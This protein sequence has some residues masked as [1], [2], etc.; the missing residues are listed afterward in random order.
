MSD[1]V[2]AT[3]AELAMRDALKSGDQDRYF[4]VLAH[5]ELLLPVPAE[6]S[7]RSQTGWGT[8]AS[9]GRTHVLAFTSP[10]A[11]RA[12]LAEHAG[13]Y[14]SMTF[15][16]L[17]ANWPDQAWWL[18]VDPG[19]AIEG[20]LPAWYI[21][22]LATKHIE[23]T[24]KAAERSADTRLLGRTL[25]A[26]A[27]IE[28]ARRLAARPPGADSPQSGQRE[29]PGE[30]R[31]VPGE[32]RGDRTLGSPPEKP[33]GQQPQ[34]EVLDSPQGLPH[35]PRSSSAPHRESNPLPIAL[36][37]L[38]E[39]PPTGR[40][41]GFGGSLPERQQ[42][43]WGLGATPPRPNRDQPQ[44][45]PQPSPLAP[46]S[47]RGQPTPSHH[48]G[49]DRRVPDDRRLPP[50]PLPTRA[51]DGGARQPGDAT[52]QHPSE[53]L[54]TRGTPR[55]GIDTGQWPVVIEGAMLESSTQP[56]RA[57]MAEAPVVPSPPS[58]VRRPMPAPTAVKA[59]EPNA[60][61]ASSG[62]DGFTPVNAV[63]ENLLEAAKQRRTDR[64]LS[65]LLLAKVLVPG[66][67]DNDVPDP[68]RWPVEEIA[69]APH[70]VAYTSLE[71]LSG[72]LGTDASGGWARFT[73]L[74]SMW[75][76]D[77]LSFAVNPD[78]PVGATLPGNEVVAL[79]SW[80][81]KMGLTDDVE[82]EAAAERATAATDEAAEAEQP[83]VMQKSVSPEQVSL[84]LDRG[85][86]RVSGFV[87][88][89]NEVDHLCTP[90][91]IYTTL[92][93]NYSGSPFGRGDD[94]VYLLRWRAYREELYRIPYGGNDETARRAMEGWMIERPPFRGNGF[95][96]CD[97]GDVI[98][99]FKV[100]SVRLPHGAQLWRL[101][102]DGTE[103][104][105]ALLDA[106]GPRWRRVGA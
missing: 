104:L 25:G 48:P 37:P 91:Q 82:T 98:A 94:M 41:L 45:Q 75:P 1:W 36:P 47:D 44:P 53:Q 15:E 9:Q 42:G 81:A 101:G 67:T 59:Q 38:P 2:P 8:W 32:R 51:R 34:R 93:L 10:T 57:P 54:P 77:H 19:L 88:R 52:R 20:Y 86:D 70:F 46:R 69:G 103:R 14:R 76:G 63:E 16:E 43:G 5:S 35:R 97:T 17:A 30:K 24:Q 18:A 60:D 31:E 73:T 58:A 87:H 66:W 21:G 96:P 23:T 56:P 80:A 106:D 68:Q 100:D 6:G 28:H 13:T 26:N 12:C 83:L 95:A 55:H 3:D 64:F 79:A 74:I 99:E 72:R 92:G 84:Y 105:I 49:L 7:G 90:E 39:V 22:Q 71:R 50:T 33:L 102:R 27:R 40:P 4:Q 29:T 61:D 65:T 11:L 62:F 89:A 78:T 85:Y